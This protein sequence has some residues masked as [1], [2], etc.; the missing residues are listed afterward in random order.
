MSVISQAEPWTGRFAVKLEQNADFPT[1]Q[2]LPIR[3][4]IYTLTVNLSVI[5]VSYGF[6]LSD[7][8][9]EYRRHIFYSSGVK[10]PLIES[11]SRQFLYATELLVACELILTTKLAPQ[12]S[13]PNSWLPVEVILAVVWILKSYCNLYSP[14]FRVFIQPAYSI[15]T[16][17]YQ[18]L[19][20]ITMMFGSGHDQPQYRLSESTSLQAPKASTQPTGSLTSP[21]N[22]GSDDGNRGPQQYQHT[23]GLN[24]F[25]YPCYDICRFRPSS[26]GRELTEWSPDYKESSCLH[27]VDGNCFCCIS[28]FAPSDALSREYTPFKMWNERHTIPAIQLQCDSGQ[29]S[30]P[31]PC[32]IDD[33]PANSCNLIHSTSAGTAYTYN[34]AG[35]LTCDM[36][37]VGKD[38]QQ[39]SCETVCRNVRALMSH[40]KNTHNRQQICNTIAVGKDGQQRPCRAVCKD[41]SALS[42]HKS[43]YHS[44]PQICAANVVGQDGQQRSCGKV[45]KNTQALL[46]HREKNH[47]GPQTCDVTVTGKDGR[48]QPCGKISNNAKALKDHKRC[49]HSGRQTCDLTVVGNNGQEQPCGRICKSIKNLQDHKRSIHS[50][51]RICEETVIGKD[52]QQGLCG[53]IHKHAKALMNHKRRE[54]SG[55]KTCNVVVAEEDGLK[56]PCGKA[57]KSAQALSNHKRI[58]RKHKTDNDLSP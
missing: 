31:Q 20:A 22:S 11:I 48:Q 34:P 46:D 58:H 53:T 32:D 7:F 23:L 17:G 10:T 47:T 3:R 18:R 8:T 24:C 44:G 12:S 19:A 52:G 36:I 4:D 45:C 57:C 54:H 15:L 29:L 39:R 50:G 14:L 27:L 40:K 35:Q 28:H 21:L 16:H 56:R 49:V 13:V 38:G 9:P 26:D 41:A 55:Q 43:K 37:L 1:G 30:E 51:Y 2:N 25:V 5:T 6:A 33:N 42:V